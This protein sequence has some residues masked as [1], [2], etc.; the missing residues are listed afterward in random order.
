MK[1][2]N[3]INIVSIDDSKL[4]NLYIITLLIILGII[5]YFG[6]KR[7]EKRLL[8]N[9]IRKM[10]TEEQVLNE[11]MKKTQTERFKENKISGLVYN[12]Q[13]EKYRVRLQEIKEELPV[14]EERLKDLKT[15]KLE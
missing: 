13:M 12:I 11:L 5:S 3:C 10:K 2:F 9:K 7:F 8:I 15:T 4:V 6:Y 1:Q 14:L